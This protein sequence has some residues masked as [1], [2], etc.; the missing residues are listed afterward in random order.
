MNHTIKT[1]KVRDLDECELRCYYEHN[2]VSVNFENKMLG[3]GKYSCEL[4]NST[5]G[6]HD[7]DFVEAPNFLYRGTNVRSLNFNVIQSP[8]LLIPYPNA[9][10]KGKQL[11]LTLWDWLGYNILQRSKIE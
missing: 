6:K 5:H 11:E 4:N 2:C 7:E 3:N 8:S 9:S 10:S 1:L